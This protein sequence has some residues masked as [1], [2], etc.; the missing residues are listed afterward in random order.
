M[1]SNLFPFFTY[2]GGK[3][4]LSLSYD[5]PLYN[6]IIEPF[7]G[8]AGYSVRYYHKDVLLYDLDEKICILWDYLINASESDI[9]SLP[10]DFDSVDDLSV[11]EGAK[12]LIGFWL[13]KGSD[14]PCKLPSKWMKGGTRP[15]S[16][17]SIYIKNRIARQLR[18]IR[19]WKI[20]NKSYVEIENENATWFID[21]PY[22]D[23]GKYYHYGSSRLNYEKLA[24]WSIER[25][26]QVIVCENYGAK[27]L[28]FSRLC[29][30][31][32]TIV[33]DGERQKSSEVVYYQIDGDKGG[34]Q[35]GLF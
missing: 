2:Y 26:G 19:H 35:L 23:A 32:S 3:W 13:S 30:S 9:L 11:S 21:P 24:N 33:K 27:W 10:I 31:N 15:K 7:A 6:R 17:W 8:S 34:R 22:V 18:Y 1:S 12:Y 20:V 16:F 25:H 29:D 28:D 5:A 14:H 4:R